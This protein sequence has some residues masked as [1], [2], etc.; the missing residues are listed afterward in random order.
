MPQAR[1]TAQSRP[2][3]RIVG[4]VNAQKAVALRALGAIY[5]LLA[6]LC[7]L[8]ATGFAFVAIVDASNPPEGISTSRLE[9]ELHELEWKKNRSWSVL[10][11]GGALALA[12]VGFISFTLVDTEEN[13]RIAANRSDS[14][15]EEMS[16]VSG[17]LAELLRLEQQ[18]LSARKRPRQPTG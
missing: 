16:S 2:D 8:A 14:I 15:A 17:T 4:Y 18:K 10:T 12:A 5:V 7:L 13:T 3:S 1:R 6:G 11:G 9:K